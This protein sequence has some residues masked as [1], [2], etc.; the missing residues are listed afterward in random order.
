M[1]VL[2]LRGR[3]Q[4]ALLI[5][6]TGVGVCLGCS[7]ALAPYLAPMNAAACTPHAACELAWSVRGQKDAHPHTLIPA[8]PIETPTPTPTTTPTPITTC[9]A[10]RPGGDV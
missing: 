3:V 9:P 1:R 2:L 4:G 10:C 7:A 6:E 5:G 8:P